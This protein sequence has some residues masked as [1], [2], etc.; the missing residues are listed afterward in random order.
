MK[1]ENK[2][3]EDKVK[4][5]ESK[6][7][8]F[9]FD[10]ENGIIIPSGIDGIHLIIATISCLNTDD[11]SF[12]VIYP[13]EAIN[14][15]VFMAV[16]FNENNTYT[17]ETRI[18]NE[19]TWKQYKY[20]TSDRNEVITIFRNYY[21]H[22]IVPDLTSWK[23]ITYEILN[24]ENSHEY[25]E[26]DYEKAKELSSLSQDELIN[27]IVQFI[28]EQSKKDGSYDESNWTTH[29]HA[30]V[31]LYFK[32]KGI[33]HFYELQNTGEYYIKLYNTYNKAAN[34][35]YEKMELQYYNKIMSYIDDCIRWGNGKVKFTKA[36]IDLFFHEKQIKVHRAEI[37]NMFY[38]KV[39]EKLKIKRPHKTT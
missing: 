17:L 23:D 39:N 20:I 32:S 31:E 9:K 18:K 13:S 26:D 37:K 29:T 33:N 10:A 11:N 15:S 8:E 30:Y 6:N 7:M 5:E 35:F 34:A 16:Q 27:D 3:M 38:T 25:D 19:S 36:E 22:N 1:G 14:S 4:K 24:R 12:F 28:I 21:C 2:K